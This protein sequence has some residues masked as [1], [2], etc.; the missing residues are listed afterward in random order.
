MQRCSNS[1][2]LYQDDNPLLA[3][4]YHKPIEGIHACLDDT[5]RVMGTPIASYDTIIGSEAVDDDLQYGNSFCGYMN[6]F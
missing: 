2:N 5:L 4:V 3:L 1:S 6:I